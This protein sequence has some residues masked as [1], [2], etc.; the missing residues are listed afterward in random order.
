MRRCAALTLLEPYPAKQG[1]KL[2]IVVVAYDSYGT[3]RTI[4]SK[5]R[6]ETPSFDQISDYCFCLLEPYPAKQ[7]LKPKFICCIR[8]TGLLLEPYPAK[9][10][11]K[12]FQQILKNMKQIL[13]E[14]Y[15]AKQGLKHR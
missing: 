11:L 12:L 5:T 10:G 13:L 4:S 9:Q 15:P 3:F 2:N 14:P 6:I 7:G 8:P 1:L